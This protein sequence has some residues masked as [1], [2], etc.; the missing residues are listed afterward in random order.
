MNILFIGDLRKVHNYGAIATTEAL[1]H[2]LEQEI[3]HAEIKIIEAR[4]MYQATPSRGFT[5]SESANENPKSLAN[6]LKRELR[7]LLPQKIKSCLRVLRKSY[8]VDFEKADFVPYK[9][10]QFESYYNEMRNGN[11]FQYEKNLL[12]WSDAVFINCEGNI[13]N[14]TDE[15]GRYRIGA[16][17]LLFMAWCAKIK[18]NKYTVIANHTV[19]PRNVN[20]FEMISNIYPY[21]DH[22]ILRETLSLELLEKHGVKNGEFAPDALFTYENQTHWHPSKELSRLIDFNNPYICVGDSSAFQNK[23]GGLKWPVAQ[24]L[25]MMIEQLKVVCP[26][27]IFVDGFNGQ[28]ED[29]NQVLKNTGIPSVNL[30][31]CDYHEL[32]HILKGALIFIS[33]RWHASILSVLANTPILLWGSDSHKTKSL[34]P[35]LDYKYRFFELDSM[36]ANL[37]ELINE[38]KKVLDESDTIKILFKEKVEKFSKEAKNNILFM[39]KDIIKSEGNKNTPPRNG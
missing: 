18:F 21:L 36:P 12:E 13:V 34:Y 15:R 27:I 24:F 1:V 23:Y 29:V 37:P 33:G 16:R 7:S 28:H 8:N 38:V 10:S 2:I 3:P 14:G 31:N 20:A 35:L 25:S 19:D 9:Y 4:S 30:T 26:Q 22:A 39:K 11:K 32:F 17:Y 6:Q 5:D